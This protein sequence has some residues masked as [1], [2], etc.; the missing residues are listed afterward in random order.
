M[1]AFDEGATS[2]D[3]IAPARSRTTP[4]RNLDYRDPDE[5]QETSLFTAE[6]EERERRI[7]S[8]EEKILAYADLYG[9][10]ASPPDDQRRLLDA[11]D[12]EMSLLPVEHKEALHRGYTVRQALQFLRI[13]E[14]DA[15]RAVRRMATYWERRRVALGNEMA[16]AEDFGGPSRSDEDYRRV[17]DMAAN[18]KDDPE[19]SAESRRWAENFVKQYHRAHLEVVLEEVE[20]LP[21]HLKTV[22]VEAQRRTDFASSLEHVLPFLLCENFDSLRTAVRMAKYWSYRVELFGSD[23][24][25]RRVAITAEELEIEYPVEY[26]SSSVGI[27]PSTDASGRHIIFVFPENTDGEIS[28]EKEG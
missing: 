17:Y 14:G 22:L 7:L 23:R 10:P 8:E 20:N 4:R 12:R 18:A 24:A 28:R 25:F 16:F 2:P 21:A 13:E 6:D 11:F 3:T 19:V 9:R 26:S 5:S 15:R 1:S 27:L